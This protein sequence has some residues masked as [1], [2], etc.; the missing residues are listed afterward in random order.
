MIYS[1]HLNKKQKGVLADLFSAG[2]TVQEALQKRKITRRT[3]YKWHSQEYFAAEFKRLLEL[4]RG[5]YQLVFARHASDIAMKLVAL[6][7]A[8]KEEI[9]RRACMD[10]IA[11]HNRKAKTQ[12]VAKNP[13]EP[14]KPLP[15]ISPEVQSKLLAYL[16]DDT[17]LDKYSDSDMQPVEDPASAE[18]I[19]PA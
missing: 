8:D 11:D 6:A 13:P 1:M 5:E 14:E 16:A 17:V 3:Y 7:A 9:A 4:T 19:T 15:E 18:N 2:I 10:V 12:I